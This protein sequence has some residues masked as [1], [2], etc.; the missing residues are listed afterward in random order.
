MQRICGL[1]QSSPLVDTG[2][3]MLSLGMSIYQYQSSE[4]SQPQYIRVVIVRCLVVLNTNDEVS[5]LEIRTRNNLLSSNNEPCPRLSYNANALVYIYNP[6]SYIRKPTISLC[7][8]TRYTT[9]L[10]AASWS[11]TSI[12]LIVFMLRIINNWK[13]T[14]RFGWDLAFAALTVVS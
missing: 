6:T 13:V 5:A 4:S 11:G 3:F 14:R 7:R 8:M 2:W 12:G 9:D 10:L 1:H